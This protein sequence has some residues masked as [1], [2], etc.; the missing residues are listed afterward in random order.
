MLHLNEPPG[1]PVFSRKGTL[2]LQFNRD[3]AAPERPPVR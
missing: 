1:R 3:G 2:K